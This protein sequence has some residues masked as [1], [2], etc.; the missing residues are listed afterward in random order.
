MDRDTPTRAWYKK[1]RAVFWGLPANGWFSPINDHAYKYSTLNL[2]FPPAI[3]KSYTIFQKAA[4]P[5]EG[6]TKRGLLYA[7]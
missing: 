6:Q 3:F 7:K 1:N 4:R 5:V 2:Y